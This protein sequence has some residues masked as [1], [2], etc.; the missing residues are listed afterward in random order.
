MAA[1]DAPVREA[2]HRHGVRNGCLTSIAPTGTISLLAGNVSSGIE[3]VFDYRYQ[4][5]LLAR[6]G[7]T[8]EQ[9]VEDYAHAQFR[10]QFGAAAPLPETFVRA[11]DLAPAE[12]LAM[13]AA[14]QPYV[15]SAI[16]KTINCP[17]DISFEAFKDVYLEAYALGLKGCTT[18]RPNAVT[19]AVLLPAAEPAKAPAKAA[20]PTLVEVVPAAERDGV[21]YMAPPLEREGVLAGYTYKL[22]WPGSDH[23]IY[24]TINDIE[25]NVHA[26]GVTRQTA[27][28]R[29]LHQHAQPRALR[30]DGGADAHDQRRVPP[31]RRR[32]LRGR[33]AEGRVRSAGRPLGFRPLRAEPA[34]RDRRGHRDA[35]AA[36]RLPA[37]GRSARRW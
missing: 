31:R 13:Q 12:H 17:E 22:K 25:Q 3:P 14:M 8:H 15:D 9:T 34:G 28:V 26:G 19:G 20:K 4:R 30:L 32:H 2:V 33:R 23:A 6:D 7:T 21:V 18:Y 37:G 35:H 10:R 16:S 11:G 5:R 27:A 36:H 1:L 29:D 24:V